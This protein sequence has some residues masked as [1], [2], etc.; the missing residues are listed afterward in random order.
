MKYPHLRITKVSENS[1][2]ID[3]GRNQTNFRFHHIQL[4][5]WKWKMF[6]NFISVF[7]QLTRLALF[8]FQMPQA[9][10]LE[11]SQNCS[12][13]ISLWLNFCDKST[14]R[15]SFLGPMLS[16]FFC[17]GSSGV[18]YLVTYKLRASSMK[19]H[20]DSCF[21]RMQTLFVERNVVRQI[22]FLFFLCEWC[23]GPFLYCAMSQS[24]CSKFGFIFLWYLDSVKKIWGPIEVTFLSWFLSCGLSA[25]HKLR[26]S[27]LKHSD[28][29]FH[30][31]QKFFVEGSIVRQLDLRFFILLTSYLRKSKIEDFRC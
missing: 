26:S 10:H 14:P 28:S 11:W 18:G 23:I 21:H 31:L 2:K 19:K 3:F 4:F 5:L 30:R 24:C 9:F 13:W 17:R 15:S 22:Y 27:N 20:K 25:A 8:F 7:F 16:T 6:E 12:T 29:C 1:D